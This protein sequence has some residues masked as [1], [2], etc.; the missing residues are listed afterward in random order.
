M[1]EVKIDKFEGPLDLLLELI[2][3]EKLDITE[4]SLSKITD[5]YLNE[6]SN[7]DPKTYDVSEFLLVAARLL[8]L[9]SKALLPSLAT[10]A[11]EAEVEDLKMQLEVYK[12]YRDAAREFGSILEKNLR[13][14]PAKKPSLSIPSFTPPKGVQ[15]P[16]LWDTFQKLLT[17]LPEELA[18]EEV[19]IPS[20]KI[21]VEEKL[22]DLNN[23]FKTKKKHKFSHLIRHSK[24]K[25]DAIITF[26]AILELVKCKKLTVTQ[27][28]NF[29]DIELTVA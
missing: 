14:Y 11:E 7:L 23:L 20:E 10:E 25:V 26:L 27:S 28:K 29:D 12:K 13:S 4:I 22:L 5:R 6:V 18:R 9:K 2:E 21:T 3:G 8:Y 19:E 1:Y 24:S 15:L 17:D 16:D